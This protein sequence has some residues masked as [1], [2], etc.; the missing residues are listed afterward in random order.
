MIDIYFEPDYGK[1]YEKMENGKCEIFEY[2]CEL[3]TVYH[4][5]IKREIETKVDDTVW[6]DLITPYGYGGPIIKRCE[7][8]KEN[9]LVNEFGHAFA[10][11]CKENNI[12]SEFIRFHPVIKNSE[13][14]KDIYDVIYM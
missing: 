6:Y 11:Y 9:A 5:F 2:T 10:Q 14:F 7:A 13:L 1:L 3:G 4:M 8:G 12:V